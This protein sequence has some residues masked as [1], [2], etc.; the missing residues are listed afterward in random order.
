MDELVS[1]MENVKVICP[2]DNLEGL[3]QSYESTKSMIANLIR[4]LDPYPKI[5]LMDSDLILNHLY[6][7]N[8]RYIDYHHRY[9]FTSNEKVDY[10]DRMIVM[11]GDKMSINLNK[12]IKND[13]ILCLLY[14]AYHIDHTILE[15]VR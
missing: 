9:I 15:V 11:Y 12:T 1:Q 8:Y 7:C 10:L 13:D 4:N 2:I 5:A 3:H 14:M 6:Q